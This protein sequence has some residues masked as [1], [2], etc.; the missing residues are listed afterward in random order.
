MGWDCRGGT[1]HSTSSRAA[2][3]SAM[4]GLG[5]RATRRDTP[6]YMGQFPALAFAL[7]HGH[8]TRG[9]GG[10]GAAALGGRDLFTGT[11]A[12]K[13]DATQGGYDAKTMIV[14]G[15]TPLEAFAIGRVT[16]DFEGGETEQVDFSKYWDQATKRI[17]SATGELTW[18][19]GEQLVTVRDAEDAGRHR[20][21]GGGTDRAPGR[22]VSNSRRPL[23]APSS[24]P[25]DDL[26]AGRSQRILIT[27]LAQ[28]KQSGSRYSPDGTELEASRHRPAAARAGAGDDQAHWCEAGRVTPCDHYGVPIARIHGAGRCGWDIRD[29]RQLPRLLLRGEALISSRHGKSAGDSR[30][31]LA[32]LR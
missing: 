18:D 19:Y 30:L 3:V 10:R 6:A 27:A 29:R 7:H 32:S 25:L 9:A 16:V 2:R 28:D 15:G 21:P 4:A 8:L 22:A 13:Q 1:P 20:P 26:P 17:R 14:D 5:C 12:L 24:R 11:D 31:N 23:S